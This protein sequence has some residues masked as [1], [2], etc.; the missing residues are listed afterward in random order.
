LERVPELCQQH[1]GQRRCAPGAVRP[2]AGSATPARSRL[3]QSWC[4]CPVHV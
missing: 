4:C 2:A 1:K 3:V